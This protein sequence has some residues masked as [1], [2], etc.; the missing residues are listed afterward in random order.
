MAFFGSLTYEKNIGMRG[1]DGGGVEVPPPGATT[2]AR[3]EK[4]A[5]PYV[6]VIVTRTDCVTARVENV[7]LA[8]RFP[9]CTATGATRTAV[10]SA[11]TGTTA[12]PGGAGR[13]RSTSPENGS[14]PSVDGNVVR[15]KPASLGW[16]VTLSVASLTEL[17]DVAFT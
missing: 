11:V 1:N 4:D 17:P 6:A 3:T 7:K 8:D 15:R 5:P 16:G 9:S 14:P 12:P 2:S 10:S 13:S